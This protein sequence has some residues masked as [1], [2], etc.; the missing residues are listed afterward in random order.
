MFPLFNWDLV[1]D[2][3]ALAFSGGVDSVFALDFLLA[4]N[5]KVTL[6]HFYHED[7]L[8]SNIELHFAKRTAEKYNL[9]LIIGYR[10]VY[11]IRTKKS[12]EQFWRDMRYKFFH[13]LDMEIISAHHLDDCIET[14]LLSI[15]HGV[16]KL[17]PFANNN[18]IRPFLLVKISQIQDWAD[19]RNLEY[20]TD[21]S[22]GLDMSKNRNRVRKY[23][24]PHS[25]EI[26]PGLYKVIT[27]M[28]VNKSILEVYPPKGVLNGA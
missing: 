4:A 3:V 14:Y 25:L 1:P 26:N 19:K 12:P 23:I 17:I 13:S 9:P 21:P 18:V 11:E 15:H 7:D 28:L 20:L 2:N 6:I 16:A 10:N 22:N 24:V 27:R 5:K 8:I